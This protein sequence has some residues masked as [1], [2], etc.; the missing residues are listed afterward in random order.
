[1]QRVPDLAG[2]ARE[3]L[4][5][6]GGSKTGGQEGTA[7]GDSLES[8][9][10]HLVT[11][12]GAATLVEVGHV[13][14]T[15]EGGVRNLLL[16]ELAQGAPAVVDVVLQETILGHQAADLGDMLLVHLLALTGEV[17]TEERLEELVEH[18]VVHAGGPAEVRHELVLGVADAPV[19]GLHDGCVPGVDVAGGQDD[20]GVRVGLDQLLGESTGG[21][22]AHG[23]AV[24]Q[25]LVP[26][27]AAELTL[28]LV[29]GVQGIVPH[30]AV[31]WVLNTGTHHVVALGVAHTLE[32]LAKG[33]E[34]S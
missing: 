12:T 34:Y 33:L 19:D 27:L 11:V 3:V 32:S 28:A 21:P 25:K 23:L 8:G 24:S 18:G 31:G 20:L 14:T 30:Q 10:H 17:A 26:F 22:V 6:H 13:V 16:E 9:V 4:E 29:L 1:M 2:K 5:G 7:N 15:G